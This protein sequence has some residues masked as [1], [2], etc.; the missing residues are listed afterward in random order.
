MRW[1]R[2]PRSL[3]LAPFRR[4]RS[5]S[6][7]EPD[8]PS[9]RP[10]A[11]TP[12][13]PLHVTA[14]FDHLVVLAD[15]LEAGTAWCEATLGAPTQPGGSHALM[16]TH[17]RLVRLGGDRDPLAYLEILAIDPAADPAC[18]VWPRGRQPAR[19]WFDLDQAALRERVRHEGPQLVAWVA[20]VPDLELATLALARLDIDGGEVLPMAR[21]TAEHTLTWRIG[22]R[23]D[24]RRPFGGALPTLIEWPLVDR[25]DTPATN[26]AATPVLGHPAQSLPDAGLRLLDLSLTTP[27][28]AALRAA[29]T[30]LGLSA[31]RVTR[32]PP[33]LSVHLRSPRGP[34][35]LQSAPPAKGELIPC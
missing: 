20:R 33:G 26:A 23:P 4:P 16:G 7:P 18:P 27:K 35:S 1:P 15:S 11:F 22:V 29:T 30:A 9:G 6:A 10:H 14:A 13:A 28:P 2:L 24:G 12:P 34:V 21:R 5:G 31:H 8:A 25:A 17:N 3:R 19:R 32:G